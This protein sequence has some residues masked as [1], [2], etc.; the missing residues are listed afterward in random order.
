MIFNAGYKARQEGNA[1]GYAQG[2]KNGL[3]ESKRIDDLEKELVWSKRLAMARKEEYLRGID[4]GRRMGYKDGVL[5]TEKKWSKI[6]A[7]AMAA[8]G[9]WLS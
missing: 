3:T 4:V 1:T 8:R 2:Y 7:D 6:H 9:D 5:D